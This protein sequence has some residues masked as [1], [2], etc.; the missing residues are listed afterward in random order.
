[1]NQV[2]SKCD[3]PRSGSCCRS[4]PTSRIL[5]GYRIRNMKISDKIPPAAEIKING[6]TT[7]VN[8]G[9][10]VLSVSALK[11]TST[12]DTYGYITFPPDH[13]RGLSKS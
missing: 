1:M 11:V 7:P 9:K 6:S 13:D 3:G 10:L 12:Q 5:T 2:F 4:Y 8:T